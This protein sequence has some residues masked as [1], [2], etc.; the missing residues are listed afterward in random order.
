MLKIAIMPLLVLSNYVSVL[1]I[2]IL[3]FGKH[4]PRR[5]NCAN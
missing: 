3:K 4:V 2:G 5:M 1:L